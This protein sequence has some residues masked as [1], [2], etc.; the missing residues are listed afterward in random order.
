MK[1]LII[2]S[3]ITASVLL[4]ACNNEKNNNTGGA[5]NDPVL[6]ESVQITNQPLSNYENAEP[7]VLTVA[8]RGIDDTAEP[9]PLQF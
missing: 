3:T 5:S 8:E 4:S 2:L 7:T 9:I 6:K 1:R